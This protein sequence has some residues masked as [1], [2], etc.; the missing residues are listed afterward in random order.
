LHCSTRHVKVAL[1]SL[2]V[3]RDAVSS[4]VVAPSLSKE[5]VLW[6]LEIK[7]ALGISKLE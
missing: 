4:G 6:W 7:E 3:Y 5:E 1:D 2:K